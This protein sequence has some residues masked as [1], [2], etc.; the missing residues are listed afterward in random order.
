[1]WA[2]TQNV[3]CCPCAPPGFIFMG[4]VTHR[5]LTATQYV[6]PLMANFDPSF[7][8]NSTVR[9]SDNGKWEI[10]W[11]VGWIL[12]AFVYLFQYQVRPLLLCSGNLFVVQWDNVRL[13][14]RE[15]EGAFTF[16]AALHQNGTITF[17][18][19]DVRHWPPPDRRHLQHHWINY[20]CV[21]T[22]GW[23]KLTNLSTSGPCLGWENEL[24]W[25]SC[26]SWTIWCLHGPAVLFSALRSELQKYQLTLISIYIY[27][28]T[29]S[30][31]V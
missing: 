19:R 7:S 6:A 2:N 30:S 4:E 12:G 11:N 9:Y 25:T 16:Q 26:Q 18:Y 22:A 31:W 24:H 27:F 14:D 10:L 3:L 8:Q 21:Q 20:C 23:P 5:M 15:A 29:D 28:K 1:M 13:K 17:G